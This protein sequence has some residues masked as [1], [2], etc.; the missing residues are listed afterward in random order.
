MAKFVLQGTFTGETVAEIIDHPG[1][2]VAAVGRAMEAVGG[3]LDQI[4]LVFGAYDFLI[5]FEAPDSVSAAGASLAVSGTG[6]FGHVET[7]ELIAP[8]EVGSVLQKAKSARGTY[9]PPST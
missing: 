8:D 7:H 1:D 6:A 5:I 9:Q 4:Y 2:R 3:T